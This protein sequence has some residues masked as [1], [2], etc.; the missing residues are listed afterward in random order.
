[1]SDNFEEENLNPNNTLQTEKTIKVTKLG[2][3]N[4][5]VLL[6]LTISGQIAWAVENTWFN[7]FV[8]DELTPNPGPIAW[9]VALSA[10]TATL[11][12][13]IMGSLSD[14]TR[15]KWGHRRPYIL[16]GYVFWGIITAIFP[17]PALLKNVGFAIVLVI[18]LDSVMTFFGSTANDAAFNAW[19]TDISD[20]T[21]RGRVQGIISFSTLFANLIA[22]GLAGIIIDTF[23]YFIFFYLLGGTVSLIGLIAGLIMKEPKFLDETIQK[24]KESLW[25][26]IINALTPRTIRK[27][28]ILFL[29]FLNM[30]ISGIGNQ[31]YFPYLFIY[32][33]HNLGFSKTMIS[34]AGASA[35]L[36]ASIASIGIGMISHKF[37]RKPQ[38]VLMVFSTGIMLLP[39]AFLHNNILFVV[40]FALQLCFQIGSGIVLMSWLQDRYPKG[41]IGKFQGVRIIFMVA[42]PMVLGAP[43]GSLIIHNFGIPAI[44]GGLYSRS[45]N[46][47]FWRNDYSFI[48]NSSL[49][50]P[51][52]CRQDS[53]KKYL[54]SIYFSAT[55]FILFSAST[56]TKFVSSNFFCFKGR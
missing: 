1:M 30:T 18:I 6:M 45:R 20:S 3:Q 56:W 27:N 2:A 53:F 40:G 36:V 16:F 55:I 23:G 44:I 43:L 21:N 14:R 29:L 15:S 47:S 28:K 35:I 17:E 10:I 46:I 19:S 51:K 22:L 9:M 13:L 50:Y 33:E 39:L 49:F 25:R 5:L 11:T 12:T 54:I 32:M 26:G 37:N 7:T 24:P 42:I 31:I 4:V 34:I 8:F 41:E 38:L 52:I 48:I